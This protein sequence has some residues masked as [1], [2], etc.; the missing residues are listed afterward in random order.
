MTMIDRPKPGS[1]LT[2]QA[3]WLLIAKTL[4]FVFA[5]ALPVLLTRTL[6]QNEYGLFKQVFLVITTATA[7]LPLGFGLS[8]YYYLPRERDAKRRG[9]VVLNILLF[10]AMMGA[11]ACLILVFWPGLIASIFRDSTIPTYAPLIGFVILFW[12]FSSFL[13][14][15]AIANQELRLATVFIVVGQLTRTILLLGAAILFDTVEA[16]IYAGLIHGAFQSLALMWY[17]MSRFR[18]FWKAFDWSL[19]LKQIAYAL[20]FGLAGL[21]YT[22]QTDLHNYFVSNRFSAATFAI[23][24][25]GVAQLPL[26]GILRES[27]SS[28]ILPRISYLQKENQPREIVVLLANAIR[29]LAAAYLPIYAFLMVVGREFLTVMFTS[30]YAESWPIFAINLTLLPLSLLEVDAVVRA[31]EGHRFFLVRLQIILSVLLVFGLFYGISRFGLIGAISVVVIVNFLLRV[32]LAVR[33]GRVLGANLKDLLLLK[34]VGKLAIA[35]AIAGL[36]AL[37]VRSVINA[38]EPKPLTVLVVCFA[39]FATAYLAM[40]LFFGVPTGDE[41]NKVRR[42]VERLQQFVFL[43][44]SADSIS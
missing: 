35:S 25:I 39:V 17:V 26:V 31:Y 1:S 6:S 7:L 8:A 9:Q 11:G 10:N 36:L 37:L 2:V 14:T 18:G 43:R 20:P 23:Y 4:A 41:R 40:V 30:A 3:L 27:V 21:L 28:V 32:V 16:L 22:I 19:T 34:D 38:G 13:D 42:S 12:L 33:F 5:F 44:R 24:S 15:A 29:K